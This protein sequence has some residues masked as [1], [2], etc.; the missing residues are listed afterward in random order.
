MKN[1]NTKKAAMFGLDA[2][3]ALAIFGALS[4]ISGAALY[5]A[6][7]N[8]KVTATLTDLTELAKAVEAE[9]IDT[10]KTLELINAHD[11]ATSDLIKSNDS[12]W[13]GPYINYLIS[14]TYSFGVFTD[15]VLDYPKIKDSTILVARIR[16]TNFLST[17]AADGTSNFRCVNDD[18]CNIAIMIVQS[19]KNGLDKIANDLDLLVDNGDGL[20][21]GKIRFFSY[22][23]GTDD[24]L[25][26]NIMSLNNYK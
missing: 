7:K 25:F 4:V 8:A 21:K 15:K 5:S 23:S 18:E 1:L 9:F 11:Y 3:I 2:R 20:N 22:T 16:S 13:K 10:G 24:R 19:S 12:N 17:N 6:I 14:T 26:Y